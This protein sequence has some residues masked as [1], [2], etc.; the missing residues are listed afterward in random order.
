MDEPTSSSCIVF[1]FTLAFATRGL[2]KLEQ[3]PRDERQYV[4]PAE[5]A[6][7][8]TKRSQSI[9]YALDLVKIAS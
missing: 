5:L 6:A 9:Q 7:E 4:A 8:S 1:Y 3:R 2:Q